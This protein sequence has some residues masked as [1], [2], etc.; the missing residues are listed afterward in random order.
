M[1]FDS[2]TSP[3][4][5]AIDSSGFLEAATAVGCT[6]IGWDTLT[7]ASDITSVA[8]RARLVES[9]ENLG[10]TCTD[11]GVLRV[12]SGRGRQD[13]ETLAD[14]IG[15]FDDAP[16]CNAVIEDPVDDS[17][18]DELKACADL[19]A[20]AGSY[21]CLEFMAYGPLPRLDAAMDIVDRVGWERCRL[22]LDS[23]HLLHSTDD[24]ASLIAL[25]HSLTPAQI[26]L[27]QVADGVGF[28]RSTV[29]FADRSRLGRR[30]PGDGDH[31]LSD[32]TRAIAAIGFT[33][34]LS[35]EVLSYG[36]GRPTPATA[37]S[38]LWKS[39]GDLT[40]DAGATAPRAQ[41]RPE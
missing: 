18:V 6:H 25:V 20:D 13:A 28:A 16:V 22:L 38:E 14:L 34:P 27:V 9:S 32:M 23:W 36:A 7:I 39:L 35:A 33:G 1:T 17:V 5:S 15:R 19:I 12:G 11:I 40:T 30:C 10:M 24:H 8:G 29:D 3:P 41:V 21:L 37:A 26:G 4:Y 31:P 2:P